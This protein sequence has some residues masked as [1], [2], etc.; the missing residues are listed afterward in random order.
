MV[1]PYAVFCY[2]GHGLINLSQENYD[3][4]MNAAN[5]RWHC[6]VCGGLAAW[7]DDWH[8]AYQAADAC[9]Q[10][11]SELGKDF[12]GRHCSTEREQHYTADGMLIERCKDCPL[13]DLE[14][15]EL[16]AEDW[17]KLMLDTPEAQ[18]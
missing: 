6:P 14:L 4:Q 8:E 16:T 1:T 11:R 12:Q 3:A 10:M 5:A 7:D 13:H 9:K 15:D 17:H 2:S 18:D